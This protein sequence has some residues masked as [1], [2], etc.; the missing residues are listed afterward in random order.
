[1][2]G[3]YPFDPTGLASSNRIT[4][5]VHTLTEINANAYRIIIPSFAPFYLDNLTVLYI[6]EN[7]IP[8]NLNEGVDFHLTLPYIGASRSVGKMVYGGISIT[9]LSLNGEYRVTYQTIGGDWTCN[10]PVV[11]SNII[12]LAYNPRI[13]TW[14]A[15][16]N[17]PEIFPAINHTVDFDALKG[18]E[19][20]INKLTEIETAILAGPTTSLTSHI[21]KMDNTYNVNKTQVGLGIVSN[22]P[23]ATDAEVL[24]RT[25]VEK[26]VTLRQIL[27]LLS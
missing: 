12:N 2:P 20:L 4:N 17:I 18:Q 23:M 9:N 21:V 27:T 3:T 1:M 24:S 19:E 14:D 16:T 26:Y 10:V 7:G 6:D 25:P 11:F 13:T 22:L 15:V 5:E 8:H